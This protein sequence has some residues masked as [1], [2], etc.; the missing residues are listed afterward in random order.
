MISIVFFGTPD[1]VL[2]IPQALLDLGCKILAVVTA[3]DRPAGRS[4]I[5]TPSPVKS[6]AQKNNVPA[7]APEKLDKNFQSEIIDYKPDVGVLAA[8]GKIIP[9]EVISLFPYG[10]L[11][12]HPSLL[13]K[14]RGASP[15]PTAI[16]SGDKETGVSII[17]IDDKVDHGPIVAQAKES[18]HPTDT[19]E[20]LLKRLFKRGAELIDQNIDKYIKG[21]LKPSEQD[22]SLA[23]FTKIFRREDGY[24]DLGN[25]PS[26]EVFNRMVRAYY[27]WPGV[28][29]R[30]KFIASPPTSTGGS[31]LKIIKFLPDRK[32]QAE[33][34]KPMGVVDFLNGYPE[35]G[36]QIKK[37][38]TSVS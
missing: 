5:L 28:W 22:H 10:I 32:I 13:P 34:G 14:Y 37:L 17:R 15:V 18:I 25:P 8:Y 11:V 20:T 21:E 3:P 16:L 38:W 2:P 6:W 12:T 19:S 36:Q 23:T 4:Q 31:K 30:I 27:P 24:I 33:G 26:P 9:R 7:L 1:F 29:T 35:S